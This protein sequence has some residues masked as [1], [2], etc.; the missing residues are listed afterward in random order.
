MAM[1]PYVICG[2]F[3]YVKEL[4]LPAAVIVDCLLHG[5]SVSAIWNVGVLFRGASMQVINYVLFH[6]G[7]IEYP[8]LGSAFRVGKLMEWDNYLDASWPNTRREP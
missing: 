1:L 3:H 6:L 5:T 7:Y 4:L 8:C 2:L